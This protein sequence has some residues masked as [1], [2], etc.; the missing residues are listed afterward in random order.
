MSL[1]GQPTCGKSASFMLSQMSAVPLQ[2]GIFEPAP[3]D[4][5]AL[6]TP[7]GLLLNCINSGAHLQSDLHKHFVESANL[8]G[9]RCA[10]RPQLPHL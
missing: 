10:S 1:L 9:P 7:G 4:E 3:D 5:D 2:A 6:A 8:P